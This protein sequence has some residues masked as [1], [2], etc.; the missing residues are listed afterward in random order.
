MWDGVSDERLA[1]Q[2]L[3]PVLKTDPNG[4][5]GGHAFECVC[6]FPITVHVNPRTYAPSPRLTLKSVV[7]DTHRRATTRADCQESGSIMPFVPAE[8]GSYLEIMASLTDLSGT[9]ENAGISSYVLVTEQTGRSQHVGLT[10][11]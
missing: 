2:N 10:A 8:K 9:A 4:E 5:R 3:L 11:P 6:F 1:D 7:N